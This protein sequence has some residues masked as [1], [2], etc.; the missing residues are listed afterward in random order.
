MTGFALRTVP[1]TG[2]II[3]NQIQALVRQHRWELLFMGT[4]VMFFHLAAMNAA[5][6]QS[7]FHEVI[8]FNDGALGILPQTVFILFGAFWAFR[9]W[10]GFH[11][12]NRSVFLSY[13]TGQL[14]HQI[15][16]IT[17]G[18]I[19]FLIIITFFWLLGATINEI[20]APGWS[21]FSSPDYRG[22]AWTVTLF[23]TLNGYLYATILALIFR[24]PEIWFLVWIPVTIW[25]FTWLV[26]RF[27]SELLN[28]VVEIVLGW[29]AGAMTGLGIAR[30]YHYPGLRY[31]LPALEILLLWTAIFGTGVYITARIHRE[32]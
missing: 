31:D 2:T 7:I 25:F 6:D 26:G 15:V 28:N 3:L 27:K 32:G 22:P 10:E 24:R 8:F 13:P 14:S 9:I 18:G 5:G 11:A 4:V 21:W 23:G 17:A 12:G 1:S 16:R 30:G 29:P 20:F 19:V